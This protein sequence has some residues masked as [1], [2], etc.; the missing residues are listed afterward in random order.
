M[1]YKCLLCDQEIVHIIA[2]GLDPHPDSDTVA[3]LD[4]NGASLATLTVL[5]TPEGLSQLH[6]FAIPFS[7]LCWAIRVA[8]NHFVGIFVAHFWIKASWLFNTTQPGPVST[9]LGTRT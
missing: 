9:G 2:L 7:T 8:G 4:P 6:Q 1:C 3:A 5:N